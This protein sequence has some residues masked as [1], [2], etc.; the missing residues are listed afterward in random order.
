MVS[1]KIVSVEDKT[2]GPAWTEEERLNALDRYQILGTP[3]EKEF[4]DIARM[5]AQIC[6]APVSAI[7]FLTA[8]KQWFK[9]EVGLGLRETPRDVAICSHAIL[10]KD[11]FI[12]PDASQDPR[13]QNNPL[14]AGDPHLRF[15]A[16]ALLE[17]PDG[18][19]LGTMCVLD[20]EP[21]VFTEEESF[22]LKMLA[23]QVMTQLDLR[24]A[25]REKERSEERLTLALE[26]SGFVGTWDWD[27]TN[28]RV[29]ADPR[30]VAIFGGEPEWV[31]SGSTISE[32]IKAIH[33]DD[34]ERVTASI[35][36]A[37]KTGEFFQEEYRLVQKD[38]SIRWIDARGRCQRDEAGRAI[39][40]PGVAV[41][42]TDRKRSEQQA[43]ELADRLHFMA[44]SMPQKIFTARPDGDVDYFNSRWMEFTGLPFE[45]IRD[46]GWKQFIHPDDIEE[47]MRRW[48]EALENNTPY[49]N[50]H[51]FR[52]HD[53]VYRWH[54][55]RA[56]P[57]CNEEGEV[58]MWIGTNTDIDD[59]RRSNENL[60]KIV[61]ERTSRLQASIAELES[62]S[63][64]ISHDMRAPLR[65]MMGFAELLKAD[66]GGQLDETANHYLD[67]IRTAS[68]RMDE[69]IQDVLSFSQVSRLGLTLEPVNVDR[70]VREILESYPHL[71]G[72]D[73]EIVI[74]EELP[75]VM[76]HEAALTQCV[77][78]LLGNAIKFVAPGIKPR[79]TVRAEKGKGRV[80]L[81]VEDNGIGIAS[82][83]YE[84]IF[85]IF[86]RLD[87][88][89][90]GTGIGLAIVKKA[91]E[92]MGSTVG[93][94]SEVGRGSSFWLDLQQA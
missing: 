41:D 37:R 40:F 68:G 78:N 56:Q 77:S 59:Q 25:L 61:A 26:S 16:G 83:E 34:L 19:P 20:Y 75:C 29:F 79:V 43:R 86:H 94:E 4:E 9:A 39:R 21:R 57:M 89:H 48:K 1:V 92:K 81:W 91:A 27:M 42:I 80:K 70:L 47:N 52:R 17:T 90:D 35:K 33:P 82:H 58:L 55:S 65:S 88:Q 10:Q 76:A 84:K 6:R 49:E 8:D 62:F 46:W 2:L 31:T 32:Y 54:L 60:E 12:V 38:G 51:R 66:Y 18:L 74:E 22:A 71:Q 45:S 15:Y 69:L 67:R 13:F 11:L 14:V 72:P 5:A 85:D 3:Q 36:L 63:Y 73:V 7:N 30:F 44:E 24:R 87:R 93:L 50:E 64:S 53:G 28:D 23:R